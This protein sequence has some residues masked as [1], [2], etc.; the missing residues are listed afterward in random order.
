VRSD[1]NAKSS[2]MSSSIGVC[3][4][5][6][7]GFG[8]AATLIVDTPSSSSSSSVSGSDIGGRMVKIWDWGPL[9]ESDPGGI[10]ATA[11]AFAPPVLPKS[12]S[13]SQS[14]SPSTSFSGTA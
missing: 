6:T 10:L 9:E 5:L 4:I 8:R 14:S 12:I 3:R 7:I 13:T 2:S 1:G 11:V